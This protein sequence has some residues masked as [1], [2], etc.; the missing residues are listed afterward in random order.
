MILFEFDI[1]GVDGVD[2]VKLEWEN[3]FNPPSDP[4]EIPTIIIVDPPYPIHIETPV[5]E[6]VFISATKKDWLSAGF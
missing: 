2:G 1:D 5:I 3:V 4:I 6:T